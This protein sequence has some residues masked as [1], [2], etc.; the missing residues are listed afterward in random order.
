MDG[1]RSHD[2]RTIHLFVGE[3]DGRADVGKTGRLNEGDDK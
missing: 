3:V 1:M 2:V